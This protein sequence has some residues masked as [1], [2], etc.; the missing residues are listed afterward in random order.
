MKHFGLRKW[1]KALI[2]A[3][4]VALGAT[5]IITP[6]AF[7]TSCSKSAKYVDV[8]DREM[9]ISSATYDSMKKELK[10]LH[11]K[12][13]EWLP[14]DE[15]ESERDFL[16]TTIN[17]FD[18][19]LQYNE[20][21]VVDSSN[22]IANALQAQAKTLS[23]NVDY[24]SL[25]GALINY[26]YD[27]YNIRLSRHSTATWQQLQNAYDG[28]RDASETYMRHSEMPAKQIYE[29]LHEADI[30]FGKIKAELYEKY[31][32]DA[33]SGLQEGISRIIECFESTNLDAAS[34]AASNRLKEMFDTFTFTFKER[35]DNANRFDI[36]KSSLEVG[37]PIS[38]ELMRTMFDCIEQKSGYPYDYNSEIVPGFTI[39]P[40]LHEIKE[41][42]FRNTFEITI[43][44]SL[45]SNKIK[46]NPDYT[47][48]QKEY[49]TGHLYAG[50]PK[51]AAGE[52]Y[53]EGTT[54]AQVL[55]DCE[56]LYLPYQLYPTAAYEAQKIGD[57]Y[58]NP[59][60]T[61]GCISLKWNDNAQSPDNKYEHFFTG[62]KEGEKTGELDAT[63]LGR[64][65]LLISHDSKH[66]EKVTDV[67]KRMES[68]DNVD[69]N[70]L[71]L[72]EQ[73][74]RFCDFKSDVTIVNPTKHF[75]TNKI[76]VCYKN[77]DVVNKRNPAR[78]YTEIPMFENNG[79]LVSREFFA[80][81]NSTFND[82]KEWVDTYRNNR[83]KEIYSKANDFACSIYASIAKTTG[84]TLYYIGLL[85]SPVPIPDVWDGGDFLDKP[86]EGAAAGLAIGEAV[87][88]ITWIV[89]VEKLLIKPLRACA[90][91][92][93][94]FCHEDVFRTIMDKISTDTKWFCLRKKPGVD[95][96][97]D[98]EYETKYQ[99][100]ATADFEQVCRPL[101][102]FYTNFHHQDLTKKFVERIDYYQIDSVTVL[103]IT[104]KLTAPTGLIDWISIGYMAL[105]LGLSIWLGP[106]VGVYIPVSTIPHFLWLGYLT[107][108]FWSNLWTVLET[109]VQ[110]I[111]ISVAISGVLWVVTHT[112]KKFMTGSF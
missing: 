86:R 100:F 57:A 104:D 21:N 6:V 71:T 83:F 66:Y 93:E 48:E 102:Q 60:A 20:I 94:Q 45:I 12:K 91:R 44:W 32:D 15:Q 103:S 72:S 108:G 36:I 41:D 10:K 26:A 82:A 47:A 110:A 58:F 29:V 101:Y 40:I 31:K 95:D 112:F 37:Q 8:I 23:A 9:G 28:Y 17:G 98:T 5:A 97:D 22:K 3:G 99:T 69:E 14:V 30:E 75:V 39:T 105:E 1:K 107:G 84:Y 81:A 76:S 89:L 2:G 11:E 18:S 88:L 35:N 55:H 53:P 92:N 70:A 80:Q 19:L 96:Y 67:L 43:D 51:I 54:T 90:K 109:K 74:V 16:E 64:S 106:I 111:V 78:Y 62:V 65:G 24:T 49:A 77:S 61:Q 33:L 13:I 85:V 68:T 59:V 27:N 73:F 87:L 52:T 25:T 79:Y 38:D 63:T 46:N 56:R 7:I 50:N 34:L 4:S 42:N